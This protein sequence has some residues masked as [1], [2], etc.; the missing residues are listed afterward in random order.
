MQTMNDFSGE[1][2]YDR[3]RFRKEHFHEFMQALGW[4]DAEGVPLWVK[5]GRARQSL[6]GSHRLG[7]DGRHRSIGSPASPG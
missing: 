5:I 6:S 2:F 7:A 1:Q 4:I 3:F